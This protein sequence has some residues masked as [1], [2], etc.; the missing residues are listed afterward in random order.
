M[1][2]PAAREPTWLTEAQVKMLHA[3]SLRLFGGLPGIRDLGLLALR[4]NLEATAVPMRFFE[5]ALKETRASVTPETEKEYQRLV[6]HL[7]QESAQPT[8]R[9][10]FQMAPAGSDSVSGNGA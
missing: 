9:L 1:N 4:E 8:R 6:E 2:S 5:Q 10:G 7:K 3:E